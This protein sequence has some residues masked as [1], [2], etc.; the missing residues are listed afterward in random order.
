M[1]TI[2][3][4]F[5]QCCNIQEVISW[6][7]IVKLLKLKDPIT[8][9]EYNS[10]FIIIDKFTKQG[11]FIAYIEEIL[12]EDVAQVYMKEVFSKY[13]VL[14]KIILDKDTR[15]ISVFQQVFITE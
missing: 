8:E 3:A 10:I 14:D 6:D 11:Y 15:F 13:R 9:Q 1:S 7:F 2:T 4:V 12:T 5:C